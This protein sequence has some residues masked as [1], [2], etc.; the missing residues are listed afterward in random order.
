MPYRISR[1]FNSSNSTFEYV[2]L[3]RNSDASLNQPLAHQVSNC[4]VLSSDVLSFIDV[5][6]LFKLESPEISFNKS[7]EGKFTS[8]FT[9]GPEIYIVPIVFLF[10]FITGVIGNGTLIY[11]LLKDGLIRTSTF[12]FILNLAFGDLLVLIGVVPYYGIECIMKKFPFA[13]LICNWL[14]FIREVS[15]NVTVITLCAM[16]I[17]RYKST[18][19]KNVLPLNQPGVG[20]N[21]EVIC[22]YALECTSFPNSSRIRKFFNFI[23]SPAGI[24]VLLIWATSLIAALPSG[25]F[26]YILEFPYAESE[27]EAEIVEVCYP[28][29]WHLGPNYDKIVVTSKLILLFV[30]PMII[31]AYCYISIAFTLSRSNSL[32]E[33]TRIKRKSTR[34]MIL[35]L[36]IF[37]ILC[38]L[39]NH[40]VMM[41]LYYF[42]PEDEKFL[43][44]WYKWRIVAFCFS[45][46]NSALNPITLYFTCSDVRPS[47]N[48][49][50]FKHVDPSNEQRNQVVLSSNGSRISV[51]RA[52]E[53]QSR[54]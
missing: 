36:V 45:S 5:E 17:D 12:I 4:S 22:C 25:Y 8:K 1:L 18:H 42:Q 49:Y 9:H 27:E 2:L 46:L 24:V 35:L 37:F 30:I 14:E 10:I 43:N 33:N 15:Q 23:K 20:G 51:T 54:L 6:K 39:P 44:V 7:F 52:I 29:P 50:L 38:F 53:D 32:S 26:A 19:S 47:F 11:G 21:S 16:S 48:T 28:H 13:P 41:W 40:L 34:K 3:T 31:I